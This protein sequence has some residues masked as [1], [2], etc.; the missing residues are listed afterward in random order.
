MP[1]RAAFGHGAAHAARVAPAL[2]RVAPALLRG[3]GALSRPRASVLTRRRR[4]RAAPR[5]AHTRAQGTLKDLQA[6]LPALEAAGWELLAV[7]AD[8]ADVSAR[9]AAELGLTFP[10]ACGLDARGMH[11]LGVYVSDPKNYQPQAYAFAEPAYFVLDGNNDGVIKYRAE[12]SHPMGARPDVEAL[13]AGWAWSRQHA[14][15]HP[16]YATHVWGKKTA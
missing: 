11:A 1:R 12:A 6:K 5:C 7:S 8:P 13:L 3:C 14:V 16:E 4:C 15:E 2:L 9:L 10:L